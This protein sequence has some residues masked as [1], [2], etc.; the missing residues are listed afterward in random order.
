M[1]TYY[2]DL[3]YLEELEELEKRASYPIKKI[4]FFSALGIVTLFLALLGL[5][6]YLAGKDPIAS[7]S[8]KTLITGETSLS[9]WKDVKY[10][11]TMSYTGT[12]TITVTNKSNT[13]LHLHDPWLEYKYFWNWLIVPANL[14][15]PV[16][17]KRQTTSPPN[18]NYEGDY[19]TVAPGKTET[20]TYTTSN[21]YGTLPEGHY[22]FL[23]DINSD[24]Y[25]IEFDVDES[26]YS[27]R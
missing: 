9:D 26:T 23:T 21:P 4:V 15:K 2:D 13:I 24:T 22:R 11:F 16:G 14:S 6:I 20:Y 10:S 25:Y 17:N 1:D 19:H 27:F 12:I 7:R 5:N 18:W 3:E 8:Q